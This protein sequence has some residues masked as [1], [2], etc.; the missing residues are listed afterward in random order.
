MAIDPAGPAA[1]RIVIVRLSAIGDAIHTLPLAA[2]LK[3]LH[4]GAY[5]GWVVEKPAAPLIVDNP[6]VDWVHVLPKGW[7]KSGRQV[8]NLRQ[9]LRRQQFELAFDVQSLSKSAVA[10]WLSGAKQ[11]VGFA[12][13]EGREIA[14]LLDNCLVQAEGVHVVDKVLSLLQGIGE[15]WRGAREFPFPAC[16]PQEKNDIGTYIQKNKIANRYC[17]LGPWGSFAAKRWPLERFGALAE[18]LR[19][20]F[21]LASLVLGQGE[22]E[23]SAVAAMVAGCSHDAVLPAPEVTLPGVVELARRAQLFVGCDSFPMHAAAAVGCPTLGLFGVTDPDRFGPYGEKAA[24]VFEKI[25]LVRSTRE[26]RRLDNA[27]LQALSVAKVATACR[28]LLL[29]R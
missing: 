24:A 8:L 6:A 14:P 26:R 11:R 16:S 3:K 5:L 25:T 15:A 17:L 29:G 7:L 19:D 28:E 23:R 1:P 13:G 4:S 18:Q 10:A 9:A 27:N 21:G 12:R 20:E 2:A 22:N